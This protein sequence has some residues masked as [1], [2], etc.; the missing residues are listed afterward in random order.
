MKKLILQSEHFNAILESYKDWLKILGYAPSTVYNLPHHLKE[1]FHYLEQRGHNNVSSITT[2]I[3]KSYYTHL[4]Q[5]KNQRRGGS[6]SKAFLNKHQ[7]ALKKFQTYI[8]EHDGKV[9]FGVHLKQEKINY[10]D[11]KVI[12]TQ[13]EIKDL[14]NA[15]QYAHMAPYF[16]ARDRAILVLLYSC[17]L[18]RNEAVHIDTEDILFQKSRIYVRKGKNYKER[19]VPINKHNLEI[20][21]E[22][23]FEYRSEFITNYQTDALLLSS[24]GKR[25]N[26]LT[27]AHRLKAIVEATLN[28]TIIEKG[29]TMHTLRHSIATHLMQNNV[30]LQM[31]SSFLGHAS[32]ESTQI[33]THLADPHAHKQ[34]VH[35]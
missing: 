19:F 6:L 29:I 26:D 30:P 15:C 20:L 14:F 35:D 5:R 7:Q 12:L 10:Q 13:A 22:Y 4:S 25:M 24:H 18:R 34:Q 11:N 1:F 31:I 8:K 28:E 23:V 17:G 27:I 16:Q 9:L 3:I 33:Y 32:L 2:H 21:E